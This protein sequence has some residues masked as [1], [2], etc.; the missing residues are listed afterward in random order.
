M[1]D[2]VKGACVKLGILEAERNYSSESLPSTGSL[3]FA[4]TVDGVM[5]CVI[6]SSMW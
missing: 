3:G 5:P 6:I 2:P 4:T 1:P